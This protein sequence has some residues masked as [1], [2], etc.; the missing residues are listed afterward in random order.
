MNHLKMPNIAAAPL[1]NKER[2]LEGFKSKNSLVSVGGGGATQ[3]GVLTHFLPLRYNPETRKR[4]EQI[5]IQFIHCSTPLVNVPGVLNQP[6]SPLVMEDPLGSILPTR[7][8]ITSSFVQLI[9]DDSGQLLLTGRDYSASNHHHFK[10][11][12]K[13][14]N[15]DANSVPLLRRWNV[16]R[17]DKSSFKDPVKNNMLSHHGSAKDM[18][19]VDYDS[20]AYEQSMSGV[21]R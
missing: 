1:Q 18:V 13:Q 3:G 6:P 5:L 17:L 15:P 8:A 14:V 12:F 21:S 7:V 9:R 11:L 4:A 10:V 2:Q 16:S 19:T 20:S